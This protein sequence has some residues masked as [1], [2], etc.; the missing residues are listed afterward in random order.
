MFKIKNNVGI[1]LDN[2]IGKEFIEKA[3]FWP[4]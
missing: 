4:Y 3:G 1:I 2:N